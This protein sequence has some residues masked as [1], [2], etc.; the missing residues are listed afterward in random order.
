LRE[1][2]LYLMEQG[3]KDVEKRLLHFILLN[4]LLLAG[5]I[6]FNIIN[7]NEANKHE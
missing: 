7:M 5:L 4:D 1:A 3:A 2:D 6:E